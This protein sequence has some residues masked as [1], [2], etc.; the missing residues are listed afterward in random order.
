VNS[1]HEQ[2]EGEGEMP[3]EEER[4]KESA[5]AVPA[6][7]KVITTLANIVIKVPRIN[8]NLHSLVTGNTLS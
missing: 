5:A 6:M 1:I 3:R 2:R 7:A 4:Q 8:I